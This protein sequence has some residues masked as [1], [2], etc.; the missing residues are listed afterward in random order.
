MMSP[1]WLFTELIV[2]IA[3]IVFVTIWRFHVLFSFSNSNF[4]PDHHTQSARKHITAT[5]SKAKDKSHT[6]TVSQSPTEKIEL[7]NNF[8]SLKLLLLWLG[9]WIALEIEFEF[10]FGIRKLTNLIN[11]RWDDPL[12]KT[13]PNKINKTNKNFSTWVMTWTLKEC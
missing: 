3:N 12:I 6:L 9:Y 4:W 13:K 11:S 8:M 7:T 10:D 2:H 1:N 5:L